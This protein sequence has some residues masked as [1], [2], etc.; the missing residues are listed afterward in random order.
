MTDVSNLGH[1]DVNDINEIEFQPKQINY[2]SVMLMSN[3][4][5]QYLTVITEMLLIT[6][7][8]NNI[9]FQQFHNIYPFNE[10]PKT[11]DF[12]NLQDNDFTE[13]HRTHGKICVHA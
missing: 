13:Q 5:Y 7:I 1:F 4:Y 8:V 9:L 6:F 10:A 11:Q 12:L 3:L 2:F